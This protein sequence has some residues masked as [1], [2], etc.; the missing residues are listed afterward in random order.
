MGKDQGGRFGQFKFG[1]GFAGCEFEV[2]LYLGAEGV[3]IE[4]FG[5]IVRD[6]CGGRRP[7]VTGRFVAY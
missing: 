7:R 5:D 6:V 1:V 3:G 2:I 4:G